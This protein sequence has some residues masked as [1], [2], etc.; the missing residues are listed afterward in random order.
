MPKRTIKHRAFTY[1]EDATDPITKRKVALEKTARRGEEV[2]LSEQDA[3]RGDKFD[4]FYTDEELARINAG[5]TPEGTFNAAAASE[6]QLVEFVESA[7][8]QEVID[9]SG[10]DPE[11]AQRLLDAEEQATGGEPRKTVVLGL[12]TVIDRSGDGSGE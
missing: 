6:E 10:G 1:Y 2:D 5:E 7:K 11:Q 3:A 4:A 8:V 12:G 9:A